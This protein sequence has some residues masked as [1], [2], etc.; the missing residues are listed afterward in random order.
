MEATIVA[1]GGGGDQLVRK[2]GT[3][4]K[5]PLHRLELHPV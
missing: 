3:G 5:G 4:R 2:L 1:R